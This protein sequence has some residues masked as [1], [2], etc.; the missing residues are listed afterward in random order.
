MLNDASDNQSSHSAQ[1]SPEVEEVLTSVLRLKYASPQY[2]SFYF[3]YFI[4]ML[5]LLCFCLSLS[6]NA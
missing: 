1:Y 6:L 2:E 5:I 4:L 3:G